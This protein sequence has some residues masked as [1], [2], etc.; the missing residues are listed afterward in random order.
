MIQTC[1]KVGR[2][3]L[4]SNFFAIV[5]TNCYCYHPHVRDLNTFLKTI[6]QKWE[7]Y[8]EGKQDFEKLLIF[9]NIKILAKS[10]KIELSEEDMA[11][12]REE[13]TLWDVMLPLYPDKNK[14]GKNLKRLF[15][16][17]FS[18]N[19]LFQMRNLFSA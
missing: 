4:S 19:V 15:R 6:H 16:L 14:K 5:I 11:M 9:P 7:Y 8:K 18:N 10:N 2:I 3:Q 1:K 13:Q 12:W 17:I